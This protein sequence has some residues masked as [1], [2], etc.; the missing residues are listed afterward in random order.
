MVRV[1]CHDVAKFNQAGATFSAGLNKAA[2][3]LGQV[4]LS[5]EVVGQLWSSSVTGAPA[6][7]VEAAAE[8]EVTPTPEDDT[9]RWR[10]RR[11]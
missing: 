10:R 2:Y 11:H 1:A 5:T 7:E 4:G 3:W 9:A 8:E 6:P